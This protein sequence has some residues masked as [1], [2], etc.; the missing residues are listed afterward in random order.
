MLFRSSP[1][2]GAGALAI[3]NNPALASLATMT[4]L[5]RVAGNL[6]I[7][8]NAALANLGAFT[9]SVKYVD[10]MLTVTN[11]AQLTDLGAFKHLALVGAITITHNQDLL[12]CRAT[13]V[14][15]CTAHPISSVISNNK[16]SNCN[17]QCN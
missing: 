2:T 10:Q 17:W 15:R 8:G 7:D 6:T 11:N 16:S 14:D 1:L 4:A 5:Y 3:K 13:E 9:T 12:A